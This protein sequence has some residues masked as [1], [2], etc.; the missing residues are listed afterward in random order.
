MLTYVQKAERRAMCSDRKGIMV[1]VNALRLYRKTCKELLDNRYTD[2]ECD[3]FSLSE[4]QLKI[5]SIESG[6]SPFRDCGKVE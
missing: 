3:S 2:G 5:D 6:D 4:F 1:I